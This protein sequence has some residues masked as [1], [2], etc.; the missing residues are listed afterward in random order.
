MIADCLLI[1]NIIGRRS[2]TT[3]PVSSF[4]G[5]SEFWQLLRSMYSGCPILL[6]FLAS[7]CRARAEMLDAV[8]LRVAGAEV[9]QL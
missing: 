7:H 9:E 4:L 2:I 3:N 1:N 5:V 6:L 8:W